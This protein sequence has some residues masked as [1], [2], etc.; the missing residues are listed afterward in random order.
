MVQILHVEVHQTLTGRDKNDTSLLMLDHIVVIP[1]VCAHVHVRICILISN[2]FMQIQSVITSS[3]V[4]TF[5]R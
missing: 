2:T 1:G 4:F 5:E 3:N